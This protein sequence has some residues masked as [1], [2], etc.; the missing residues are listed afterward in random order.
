AFPARRASDLDEAWSDMT[1]FLDVLTLDVPSWGVRVA[2]TT[3][4]STMTPLLAMAPTARN[5]WIAVTEMPWP[6]EMVACLA[7][8]QSLAGGRSP[9]DSP[10]R[11]IPVLSPKP[12]LFSASCIC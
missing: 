10:G 12:N 7:S 9:A 6:K 8:L 1:R 3:V 2:D 11:S 4:G 5:I